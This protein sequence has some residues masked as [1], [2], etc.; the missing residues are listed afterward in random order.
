MFSY[1]NIVVQEQN[2]I[3]AD[4]LQ[5]SILY[6]A[7]LVNLMF[8]RYSD[9]I[10]EGAD[11]IKATDSEITISPGLIKYN[12]RIYHTNE[13]S[14]IRYQKN[15]TRN[16]LKIRFLDRELVANGEV[17]NTEI[18][19]SETE[20]C[21]PYE[22]EIARFVPDK[23]ATLC[24]KPDTFESL[25]IEHNH[26]DVR[27]AKYAA[28]DKPTISPLITTVFAKDMMEADMKE[29]IDMA[30]VFTCLEYKQV[31]RDQISAYISYKRKNKKLEY[32]NAEIYTELLQ[33]LKETK[34]NIGMQRNDRQ[35]SFRS[36][37]VD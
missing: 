20:E 27:Y 35:R 1:K 13:I 25:S 29:D 3:R 22:F 24:V 14:H 37:I 26:I 30:F 23:G 4:M 5:Q 19:L 34:Q 33:I 10:I 32:T 8:Q 7:E 12:N 15:N 9:G 6:P 16:Y 2:I 21:F 36:I 31:N 28:I 11:I 18:V 17:F